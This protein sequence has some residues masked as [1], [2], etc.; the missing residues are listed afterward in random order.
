[1]PAFQTLAKRKLN[2]EEGNQGA[3]KR[4]ATVH[5]VQGNL[6]TREAGDSSAPAAEQ[7]WMVQW[8]GHITST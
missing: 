4:V 8:Y 7:Y 1:M 6:A 3:S 2:G 5:S